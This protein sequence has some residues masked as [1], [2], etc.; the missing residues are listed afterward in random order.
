MIE[1][2]IININLYNEW[3]WNIHNTECPI[4]KIDFDENDNDLII[5]VCNHA[6]HKECIE[7]WIKRKC[8]CPLCNGVWKKKELN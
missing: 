8:I 3:T 5:G 4:C 6:Y 7:M 2:E 1:V